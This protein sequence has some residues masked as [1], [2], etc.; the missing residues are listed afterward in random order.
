[1]TFLCV[2]S[3]GWELRWMVIF[4]DYIHPT[5]YTYI[6]MDFGCY[7]KNHPE[8]LTP[9]PP[10]RNQPI[11]MGN[12]SPVQKVVSSIAPRLICKR[13]IDLTV[14]LS[15]YH[16]AAINPMEEKHFATALSHWFQYA[17]SPHKGPWRRAFDVF[18][19]LRLN[20]RLSKQSKRRAY[21]DVA[22][23]C[24]PTATTHT[25]NLTGEGETQGVFWYD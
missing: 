18:F 9:T 21:Y 4:C 12:V 13:N 23:M 6:P 19:D 16:R 22:V 24:N 20:K 2:I 8:F 3:Y 14:L 7:E 1:M 10:P 17:N 15:T 25:T 5:I 11:Q